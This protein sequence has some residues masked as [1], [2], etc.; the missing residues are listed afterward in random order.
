[1]REFS[2]AAAL[3]TLLLRA[4][5]A[6]AAVLLGHQLIS[7]SAYRQPLDFAIHFSG[8]MAIA[9]FAYHALGCFAPVVGELRPV[10]RY[11]FSFALACTVGLFWEFGELFSDIVLRTHIQRTI[12]GTMRD[13]IADTTGAL[14]TLALVFL[15]QLLRGRS[16]A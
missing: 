16:R 6:P 15:W 11:L 9:F 14:L 12:R 1:M 2:V 3:G 7:R 13:L 4:A 8:G 5:W 10:G